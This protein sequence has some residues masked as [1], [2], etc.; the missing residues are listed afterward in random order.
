MKQWIPKVRQ[1]PWD[2]WDKSQAALLCTR[3]LAKARATELELW[4]GSAMAQQVEKRRV[5]LRGSAKGA[6][7]M[8]S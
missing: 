7:G 6:L 3:L 2:R 8:R 1:V 5:A 4:S